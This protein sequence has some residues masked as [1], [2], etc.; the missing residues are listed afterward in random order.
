MLMDAASRMPIT[1]L[2]V[3]GLGRHL[4]AFIDGRY[5]RNLYW[6]EGAFMRLDLRAGGLNGTEPS[7]WPR[8][9]AFSELSE[10]C[11]N[12]QGYPQIPSRETSV[13]GNI[14]EGFHET[15]SRAYGI[16]KYN[17]EGNRSIVDPSVMSIA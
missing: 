1:P 11:L 12:S 4:L 10:R 3:E 8:P 6:K 15:H 2:E 9:R 13:I 14:D 7:P 16:H 5:A 17:W